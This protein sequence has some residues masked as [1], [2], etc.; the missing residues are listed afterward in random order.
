MESKK[1]C[2]F[3]SQR[4]K[5]EQTII[6]IGCGDGYLCNCLA[7]KLKSRIV[8]LDISNKGFDKAHNLCEKFNTCNFIEC[9]KGKA[10]DLQKVI[11]NKKFDT[12]IFSHSFHHIKDTNKALIGV[13]KVLRKDGCVII[14]E[15]SREYGK[16]KDKCKRFTVG[17]V[18]DL[19]V[20]NNFKNI[21]IEE[22]EK[23]FFIF[24]AK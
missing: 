17:F 24:T 19:L 6:D 13:K 22:T 20:K 11:G 12:A 14:A 3:L 16:K 10:E 8:G 5:K 2:Q 15:Y 1:L 9:F 7:Q 23:G 4:L 18:V 21:A